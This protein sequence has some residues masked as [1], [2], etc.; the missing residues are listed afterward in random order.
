M[1][2]EPHDDT[3][4]QEVIEGG[5]LK[6]AIKELGVLGFVREVIC[7]WLRHWQDWKELNT[8]DEP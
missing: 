6:E 2:R 5:L 8:P 3:L 7:A 1:N 4:R